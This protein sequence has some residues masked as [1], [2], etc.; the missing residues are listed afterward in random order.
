MT[1][2]EFRAAVQAGEGPVSD[3]RSIEAAR[4]GVPAQSVVDAEVRLDIEGSYVLTAAIPAFD[5]QG[6][7][8]W[9]RYH[10]DIIIKV[11][12]D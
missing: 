11:V 3:G 2:E 8:V 9:D 4:S 6:L 1:L 5:E 12:G 10:A 7:M